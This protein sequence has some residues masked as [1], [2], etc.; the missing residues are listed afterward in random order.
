MEDV[1]QHGHAVRATLKRLMLGLH[2]RL[3]LLSPRGGPARS[4]RERVPR[5][6]STGAPMSASL[7][8][9]PC[10]S[11]AP[12]SLHQHQYQHRS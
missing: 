4:D 11:A 1:V 6:L 9:G 12:A 7:R 8:L 5:L 3:C 10:S 2:H